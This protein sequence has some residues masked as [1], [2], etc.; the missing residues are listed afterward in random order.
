[1]NLRS[2]TLNKEQGSKNFE[3]YNSSNFTSTFEIP[4]SLFNIQGG[5][6]REQGQGRGRRHAFTSP[7]NFKNFINFPLVALLQLIRP[8]I[9][10]CSC[11]PRIAEYVVHDGTC[12]RCITG[13]DGG[14][15]AANTEVCSIGKRRSSIS[16]A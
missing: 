3:G 6:D 8:H 12:H 1:M 11:D 2:G 7:F 10:G 15:T 5:Q 14:R 16:Q 13:I 4:C 9:R